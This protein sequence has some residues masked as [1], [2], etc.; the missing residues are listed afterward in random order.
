MSIAHPVRVL[1][2]RLEFHQIHH[3]DHPNLQL[4]E[5]LAHQIDGGESFDCGHVAAAGHDYIRLATLVV[6]GPRPDADAGGA[7]FDG[8]VHIEPLRRG[9]FTRYDHIHVVAAAQAMGGHGEKR[10]SIGW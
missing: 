5:L 4:R 9:L 1:A 3:V 7:M 6:T 8:R 2:L 10:V